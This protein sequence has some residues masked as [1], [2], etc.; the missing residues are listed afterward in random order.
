MMRGGDPG[1]ARDL[2]DEVRELLARHGVPHAE[3]G[4]ARLDA[5]RRIAMI[6]THGYWGD[7]PPAGATDTGGQTLY[8]LQISKECARA[9]RDVVI[10][11]RWFAPCPRVE[12][13]EPGLWLIRIPAGG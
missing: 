6:S 5:C 13:L 1:L 3:P 8:V 2:L 12:Q 4:A 7:P 10:I 11:A 9:G